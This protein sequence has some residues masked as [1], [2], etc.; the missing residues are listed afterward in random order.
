MEETTFEVIGNY[1]LFI[2]WLTGPFEYSLCTT[3]DFDM[4]SFSQKYPQYK[5]LDIYELDILIIKD[6]LPTIN[7]NNLYKGKRIYHYFVDVLSRG[8][9]YAYDLFRGNIVIDDDVYSQM[10]R[11]F[12]FT[13]ND[14]KDYLP[15]FIPEKKIRSILEKDEDTYFS[16]I[17][18]KG[19]LIAWFIILDNNFENLLKEYIPEYDSIKASYWEDFFVDDKSV[20]NG[21]LRYLKHC[22]EEKL[23][24]EKE[25][26]D[27]PMTTKQYT[28]VNNSGEKV[29]G[30]LGPSIYNFHTSS[31]DGMR[32]LYSSYDVEKYIIMKNVFDIETVDVE[33]LKKEY[34][35]IFSQIGKVNYLYI[36][37]YDPSGVIYIKITINGHGQY[38]G[39]Y[40]TKTF[41]GGLFNGRLK[42]CIEVLEQEFLDLT[43]NLNKSNK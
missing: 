35:D 10:I 39:D 32:K 27:F 16:G 21:Y 30:D 36:D 43:N 3:D 8:N 11:Y 37:L 22:I 19:Y 42:E 6:I 23:G 13:M 15:I 4:D 26:S 1:E 34:I 28:Y 2:D 20:E 41:S 29:T 18:I 9:R 5:G 24:S 31:E 38:K 40:I 33:K 25:D 14:K 17:D 12:Y 7:I